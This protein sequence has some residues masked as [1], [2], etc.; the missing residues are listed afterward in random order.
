[1]QSKVAQKPVA[2]APRSAVGRGFGS[3]ARLVL[4]YTAFCSA[5]L[6]SVKAQGA[7]PLGDRS[8]HVLSVALVRG[9]SGVFNMVWPRHDPNLFTVVRVR[10][11]LFENRT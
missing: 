4:I 7:V 1:M 8:Y 11:A 9:A 6:V 2:W 5:G 3:L 10:G